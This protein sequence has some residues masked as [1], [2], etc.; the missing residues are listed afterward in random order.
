MIVYAYGA[1]ASALIALTGWVVRT[2]IIDRIRKIEETHAASS[3]AQGKRIGD[4]ESWVTAH[5]A[6]ERERRRVDT[7]GVPRGGDGE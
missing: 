5:D 1:V 3:A 7:R 2:L 6:V 4:I